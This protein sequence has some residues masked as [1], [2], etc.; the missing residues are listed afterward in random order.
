MFAEQ[1][2][3]LIKP[4]KEYEFAVDFTDDP[5]YGDKNGDYRR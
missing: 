3:H 1:I 5:D 2:K 4:G